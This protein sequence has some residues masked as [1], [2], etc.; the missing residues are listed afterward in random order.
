M[1]ELEHEIRRPQESASAVTDARINELGDWRSKTLAKVPNHTRGRR[2]VDDAVMR[3]DLADLG[4]KTQDQV[5]GC[6]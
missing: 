1:E 4:R 5:L 3:D 2:A 6:G